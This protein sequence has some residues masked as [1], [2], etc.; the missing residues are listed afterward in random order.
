M[1]VLPPRLVLKL[2]ML[3]EICAGNYD[4]QDGIFNGVDRIIKSYT[5]TSKLDTIWIKFH[6]PKIGQRQSNKL[7]SLYTPNI[8]NDW[9]PILRSS[10]PIPKIG[11]T[12][13][14]KIWK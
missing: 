8:S 5:K 13:N 12:G 1:A 6:D 2:N 7:S 3:V 9:I 14:L 11:K 4:S 10:K